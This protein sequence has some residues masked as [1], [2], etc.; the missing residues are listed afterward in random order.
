MPGGSFDVDQKA[1]DLVELRKQASAPDLWDDPESAKKI[2]RLLARSQQTIQG[3][4]DF[5]RALDDAEVLLDL[6]EAEEDAATVE[7]VTKELVV[8]E[9]RL[10]SLERES[11]F[12]GEYDD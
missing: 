9:D 12:F 11:L 7:E 2:T 5:E 8:L 6:G 1:Q 10:A 3:V 4:E